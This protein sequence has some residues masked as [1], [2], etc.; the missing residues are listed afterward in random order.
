MDFDN[1]YIISC[2]AIL[3]ATGLYLKFISLGKKTYNRITETYQ[4]GFD[5]EA[6]LSK[7][8]TLCGYEIYKVTK[9]FT[10][11]IYYNANYISI[12]LGRT[13]ENNERHLVVLALEINDDCHYCVTNNYSKLTS[14]DNKE[15]EYSRYITFKNYNKIR[16]DIKSTLK[17]ET[18]NK[19]IEFIENSDGNIII[20]KLKK[21]DYCFVMNYIDRQGEKIIYGSILRDVVEKYISV[22]YGVY[23]IVPFIFGALYIMYGLFQQ[24]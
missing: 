10:P 23:Y 8:N 14:T 16:D 1:L 3:L 4:D 13:T 11:P 9:T 2:G 20:K 7:N 19:L 5:G 17:E 21:V 15:Y 6:K 22:M 24:K 12:P 18:A